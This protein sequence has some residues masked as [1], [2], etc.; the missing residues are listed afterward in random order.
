MG[1]LEFFVDKPSLRKEAGVLDDILI[2]ALQGI[3]QNDKQSPKHEQQYYDTILSMTQNGVR[4]Q[5]IGFYQ[6]TYS[7]IKRSIDLSK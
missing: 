4:S 3:A 2:V 7:M 5:V 1:E 6:S